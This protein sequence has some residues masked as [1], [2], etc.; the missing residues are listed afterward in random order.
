MADTNSKRAKTGASAKG[1]SK[2]GQKSGSESARQPSSAP[3]ASRDSATMPKASEAASGGAGGQDASQAGQS[4]AQ[5]PSGAND[6]ATIGKV[7]PNAA[8]KNDGKDGD[9]GDSKSPSAV[10][11]AKGKVSGAKDKANSLKDKGKDAAALASGDLSSLKKSGSG[12]DSEPTSKVGKGVKKAKQNLKQDLTGST[13]PNDAGAQGASAGNDDEAPSRKG[14]AKKTALKGAAGGKGGATAYGVQMISRAMAFMAT[15]AST[16]AQAATSGLAAVLAWIQNVGATI[17]S[18]ALSVGAA[19][20]G[21][22]GIST[23]VATAVVSVV[24]I[25]GIGT[26]ATLGAAAFTVQPGVY[27]GRLEDC[28][29][30]VDSA[31]SDGQDD[32]DLMTDVEAQRHAYVEKVYSILSA[33]GL[34][35]NEIAGAVGNMAAE[36]GIDPTGVE[37]VEGGIEAYN[38]N[39]TKHQKALSDPD[40]WTRDVIFAG[41]E[42]GHVSYYAPQYWD[43]IN[44]RYFMGVGMIQVTNGYR[45]V[46]VAEGMGKDWWDFDWQMA[47]YLSQG[48]NCTTGH[49]GGSDFW[50]TY[51]NEMQG[52]SVEECAQYFARYYEGNTV[53]GQNAR[54]TLAQEWSNKFSGMTKDETYA[55]SI[56]AMADQMRAGTADEVVAE[57]Q[58]K[59]VKTKTVDVSSLATAAVAYAW[60]TSADSRGN[61]GTALY[62]A[63]RDGVFPSEKSFPYMSCDSGVATAVRWAGVDVSYPIGNT[64]TQHTYL[65]TSDKWESLGYSDTISYDELQPGDIFVLGD[66]ESPTG[67]VWSGHTVMFVGNEAIKAKYA[68]APDS[69]DTV[70]ASYGQRSPACGGEVGYLLQK[71]YDS[72]GRSHYEVFRI[73]TPDNSDEFKDLGAGLSGTEQ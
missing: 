67:S 7:D 21:V 24:A 49:K 35:D 70:S 8:D 4:S 23:T 16:A 66:G 48:S 55:K 51:K 50:T 44:N 1:S 28:S 46:G 9:K 42:R 54:V 2:S 13:D 59:C 36:S 72:V 3:Q 31:I 45:M 73:K 32:G 39:G 47:F 71:G 6:M 43:S 61:N 22:L 29:S 63:V 58:A 10:D 19:V 41:Y 52:A 65:S 38:I 69:F 68:D 26:I 17:A 37:G 11:K 27:E 34:T 5:T 25:G 56:F 60:P 57:E 18:T 62:R 14:S 30:K 53:N 33:Y 40:A 20:G 64:N 12:S 15:A